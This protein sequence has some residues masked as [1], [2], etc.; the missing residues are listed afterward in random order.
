MH[1]FYGSPPMDHVVEVFTID[2][3][4]WMF[5]FSVTTKRNLIRTN[6]EMKFEILK[7]LFMFQTADFT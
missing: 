5:L 4:V 6:I 3:T 2:V 7:S 1:T